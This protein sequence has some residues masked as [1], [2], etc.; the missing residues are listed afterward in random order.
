MDNDRSPRGAEAILQWVRRIPRAVYPGTGITVNDWLGGREYLVRGHLKNIFAG[1]PERKGE[2]GFGPDAR[3]VIGARGSEN[4][5]MTVVHHEASHDLD[6]Y[7]RRDPELAR[8]W[9][10]LLVAA[11]GPEMRADP[12]T[13]WLSLDRTRARF[14]EAG[15]WDGRNETWKEAWKAYW[16]KPPGSDWKASGFMRGD[17]PFFYESP[18]ESLATQGN[19]HWN[20]SEGRLQVAADRWLR[21]Y[22]SNLTEVLFF[23]E[24]WS[25]GLDKGL[26]FETDDATNQVIRYVRFGRTPAGHIDTI[27]LGDRRY[28]FTV[29]AAGV[30]TDIRHLPAPP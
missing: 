6:A 27:D 5:F 1:S 4:Q 26:F 20:S 7:V 23:I 24:L 13:G 29:N 19:Q 16:D 12:A 8:R 21:G 3:P 30:V 9:G 2:Y 22:Q 11:G 25:V 10:R 18:Q 17:I 14:R 15:L 28:E